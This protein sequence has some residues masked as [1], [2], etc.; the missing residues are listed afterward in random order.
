MLSLLFI[1]A[2]WSPAGEGLT[3]WHLFVMLIVFVSLSHVVSWARWYLIV[4]I[5][6]LCCLSYFQKDD[7][8]MIFFYQINSIQ[9]SIMTEL[10]QF[11]YL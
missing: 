6:D 5:P 3:S 8:I 4:S 1:A 7:G 9:T 2:F 10:V 11:S